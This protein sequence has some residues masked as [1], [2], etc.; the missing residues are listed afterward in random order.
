MFAME[1]YIISTDTTCDLPLD[2]CQSNDIDIHSL[3]YKINVDSQGTVSDG[4]TVYGGDKQLE[5][6]V[7][8]SAMRGGSMPTTMASNPEESKEFFRK[9]VRDGYDVIHIA[10]SSGLSS[11]C[12]NTSIAASEIMEEF[13]GS[14]I[15]VI[16]SLAASMGEGLLVYKAVEFMKQGH[17]YDETVS[18]VESVKLNISHQFTVDDLFHLHRGGRVSKTTAIIGT[19]VGIKPLLH[20]DD[21]GHLISIGKTRGRRKSLSALVDKMISTIGSHDNRTV[22]ISHGDSLED[23]EYVASL[24]REKTDVKD[25]IIN[26]I[27][28]TI[29]A[30]SGPGTIALFFEADKR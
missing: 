13:P 29:G 5:P 11:S 8:Y 4:E 6:K 28:P 26:Y 12:Q 25:I 2:Y 23:A 21:E 24:I 22:M 1:K 10:F 30:H 27:C 20:V 16:D 7:F 17:T 9:R 19:I 18:Y 14:R 15:T 3:Y